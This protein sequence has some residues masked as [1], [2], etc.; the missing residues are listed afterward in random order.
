MSWRGPRRKKGGEKRCKENGRNSWNRYQKRGKGFWG[1]AGCVDTKQGRVRRDWWKTRKRAA[2]IILNGKA[3][4]RGR[5]SRAGTV[6]R[7]R[8]RWRNEVGLGG[9]SHTPVPRRTEG[10][11]AQIGK[12]RKV[13]G[14]GVG[15]NAKPWEGVKKRKM[16]T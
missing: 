3:E 12:S 5:L 1:L 15:A 2:G 13:T 10:Q 7:G 4:N 8:K 6:T 16:W 14:E 9:K 11:V